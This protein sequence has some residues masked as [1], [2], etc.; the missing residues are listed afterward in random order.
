MIKSIESEI[1]LESWLSDDECESGSIVFSLNW[2]YLYT[3]FAKN[4]FEIN[5]N[6][7]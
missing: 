4:M 6:P 1:E 7:A 2:A 3:A 5:A